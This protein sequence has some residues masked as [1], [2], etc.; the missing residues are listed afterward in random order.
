MKKWWLIG[1]MLLTTIAAH[2]QSAP[3]ALQLLREVNAKFSKVKN[4]QA[5]AVIDTR[6]SFL[7]I[8]PQ[9]AKIYFRQPDQF[10]VKSKGIAILP[11]QNFDQLFKLIANEQSYMAFI[12]GEEVYNGRRVKLVNIIPVAD[13][14]DLV[15]AKVYVDPERDLI[16]K[17][18]LTTKSNGTVLIEYQHGT[19]AD[20]ALP[21]KITFTIEVKKFKIPKAVAADINSKAKSPSTK[22]PKTGQI[23]ISFS[24]YILNKGVPDEFFR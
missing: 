17:A 22:E 3:E 19:M 10:K 5:D 6:I 7:K 11:R 23:I 9:R 8:L 15:L 14:S 16:L 1:C 4:Y 2:A 20:V 18:Q 21:D 24:N 13:T 12:S